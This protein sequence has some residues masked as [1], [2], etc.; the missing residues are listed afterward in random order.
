M[1]YIERSSLRFYVNHFVVYIFKLK[2]KKME[3]VQ[4][5]LEKING[6][7]EVLSPISFQEFK[8]NYWENEVLVVQRN[9]EHYYNS[10]F[11]FKEFD[12]ILKHSVSSGE[13]ISVVRNAESFEKKNPSDF[14]KPDGS[15]NLNQLYALYADGFSIV[16][17]RV[18]CFEKEI[19][20]LVNSLRI[21]LSSNIGANMYLTPANQKAF[22]SHYD[23]H[24]VFVLQLH[25]EKKWNIYDNT[26]FPIPLVN[27]PQ[28]NFKREE[29][30][31][32]KEVTIKSGDFMYIPRGVPHDA[33]TED[34]SSLHITIGVY[35]I[36]W[37][38][39]FQ[40]FIQII[41]YRE[42]E[43][44]K[45]LPL[46]FFGENSSTNISEQLKTNSDIISDHFLDQRNVDI[47]LAQLFDEHRKSLDTNS[48]SNF[49][50]IDKMQ[51]VNL[52][53]FLQQRNNM[54]CKVY[55]DRVSTRIVFA[56]N[57]V[58]G[59]SRIS[60]TFQF[61]ADQKG[62]FAVNDIPNVNEKNKIRIAKRLIRGGLLKIVTNN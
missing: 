34:K 35:P 16:I 26:N 30:T 21:D 9:D 46:G 61:I 31:L 44:R 45:S 58:K 18:H 56:G 51:N 11:T 36:Q 4:S 28:P 12:Q 42:V 24:G 54:S 14:Q 47:T 7:S 59:P 53:T 37:M 27:S 19:N 10:L 1:I 2:L 22:A 55:N 23:S 49:M 32:V 5:K 25:G 6:I 50:N 43:L 41:G 3:T 39:F 20:N 60:S 13:N 57:T 29:L 17:N 48:D 52:D 62:R 8:E 40:K 33:Y 15:I 38:D